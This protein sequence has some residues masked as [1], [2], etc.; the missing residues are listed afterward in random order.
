MIIILVSRMG[1]FVPYFLIIYYFSNESPK[2][3]YFYSFKMSYIFTSA[4]AV[5][6]YLYGKDENKCLL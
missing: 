3:L 5:S 6:V 1:F 4:F 2:I